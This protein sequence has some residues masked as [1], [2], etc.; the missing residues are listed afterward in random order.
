M[1]AARFLAIAWLASAAVAAA[2]AQPRPR[3]TIVGAGAT[4]PYPIYSAWFAEYAKIRPDVE[5]SYQSIGSGGG[6]R[7]LTDQFRRAS[8]ISRPSSARSCR[9]T[10]CPASSVR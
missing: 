10:T 9:S 5:I 8:S 6:I 7:Q 4:F 3:T 2:P 1:R